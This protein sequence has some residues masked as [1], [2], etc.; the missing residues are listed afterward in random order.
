M[1]M[2]SIVSLLEFECINPVAIFRTKG[3]R[4]NIEFLEILVPRFE[5]VELIRILEPITI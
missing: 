3:T 4:L 2:C 5:F 1:E